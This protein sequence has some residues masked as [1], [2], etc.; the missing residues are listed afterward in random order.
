MDQGNDVRG[1]G[2]SA[3]EKQ[4]GGSHYRD[5]VIQPVEYILAN[6][7]GFIEGCVVKYVSRHKSK[8]GVEDLRK[9]R[10]FLDLLIEHETRDEP[11]GWGEK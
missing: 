4:V 10:H 9:A 8:G 11:K 5:M 2:M 3:L 1:G 6:G 7:L